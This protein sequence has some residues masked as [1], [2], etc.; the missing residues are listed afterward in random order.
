[1]RPTIAHL[2]AI[3]LFTYSRSSLLDA[4]N[5]L[6]QVSDIAPALDKVTPESLRYRALVDAAIISYARPFTTCFLPPNR[7]VKP[8]GDVRPPEHLTE[9]HEH[10]LILRDTMIGH[11]DAT[12]AK[13]Y[14][15]SPNIVVVR[16]W[17]GNLS[18][19]GTMI[20]DMYPELK[21]A[22]TEL[23]AHFV[24]HC[25]SNLSQSRKRYLSEFMQ[26]PTGQYELVIS[27]PPADWLTPFRTKH[28][29]DYRA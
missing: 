5:F 29:E 23:C 25:E 6:G 22:L 10:A 17:N 28:G 8:L 9:A 16:I 26:H 13:G 4:A 21:N 14:T 24:K 12:P 18:L 1:M 7:R 3:W 20:G 27:E 15:A 2:Q 19:N 11:K